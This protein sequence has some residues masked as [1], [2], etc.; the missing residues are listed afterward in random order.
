MSSKCNKVHWASMKCAVS[1]VHTICK[2]ATH[3]HSQARKATMLSTCDLDR[4]FC[5]W[6]NS[7]YV[8]ICVSGDI[9]KQ[10]NTSVQIAHHR[11]QLECRQLT[12]NNCQLDSFVILCNFDHGSSTY[13]GLQRLITSLNFSWSP[14]LHAIAFLNQPSFSDHVCH[15]YREKV[16]FKLLRW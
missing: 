14:V 10:E 2:Y 7:K 1:N 5:S 13:L 3:D 12:H 9:S 4:K 15:I 16:C 11:H 6:L 8:P